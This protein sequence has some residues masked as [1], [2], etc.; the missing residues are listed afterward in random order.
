MIKRKIR[1][2]LK[3][4]LK[5]LNLIEKDIPFEVERPKREDLGDFS[6]NLALVLQGVL[7]AKPREIAERII[8]KLRLEGDL[9]EKIEIAGPGF[10]NFWINPEFLRKNLLQILKEKDNYGALNIGKGQRIHIEFVSAN[11]TG[12]LHI[13][14]GRGAAYG[15]ALA[16]I[17]KFAGF[18]VHTE[19]YINDRG[20]QMNIL[21]ASVYLRA[22]ELTGEKVPFPED[23]YQGD[24]IYDIAKEALKLYPDL[25]QKAESEAIELCR[26]LAIKS[27][28]EDIRLD[29]K[30]FRV[31]YDHWYSE[32]DLY[33]KSL[34]EEVLSL[35]IDK[36]YLYE[37]EGALWFKS[38]LFGDE[39]DRVVRKSSGEWTY[40][41]SDISYHYE[42]FI[43]RGFDLAI[44]LWGA[45]H[46]GYVQRLKGVLKAL[47]I[48]PER[49]K[50]LLIQMVNLLEGGELKS[51]STRKAEYIE[52]K[53]LVREVGVDA[54][55]FIFLSRSQ[56]SPLD[57]DV[58]LAKK[59]SQ[60]N[61]VY[62]VQYAHARICSIK[63]KAKSEGFPLDELYEAKLFLLSEKE[64]L[65]LMKKLAEF[66][67][68]VEISALQFAPY[69]IVYYLLEL[70]GLFHEYYN[71]Y[72]VVGEEKEISLARLAL[73]EGCRIII[74]RGLTLLGVNSPEKM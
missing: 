6:T 60:E 27:I 36:G 23:Y 14:H 49:L 2:R 64:S 47:G 32:R 74:Q 70:A 18:N 37:A 5:E 45:D 44:D 8:E 69:K 30:N 42:K 7:K 43:K 10:I 25:M 57:F 33:K 41:A 55:R 48:D 56:D 65:D 50:V 31:E 71:K 59:Q 73:T 51:M 53:E 15:D 17:L 3:E 21:G 66:S 35:L 11:P 52:L 9:F 67:D 68:V 39:K 58:E 20:T 29:L 61:P 13:G 28:L 22:K 72:R 62:Y 4:T 38:T 16:R 1:E 34:V 54:V 24:Y 63:E 12:P 26:E 19:Y 40:F 46:H